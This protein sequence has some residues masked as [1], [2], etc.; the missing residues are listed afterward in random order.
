MMVSQL[1]SFMPGGKL[2]GY[3]LGSVVAVI[4]DYNDLMVFDQFGQHLNRLLDQLG[5]IFPLI[6]AGE[7]YRYFFYLFKVI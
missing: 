7:K 1:A 5:N 2:F 4:V 3:L 6:L